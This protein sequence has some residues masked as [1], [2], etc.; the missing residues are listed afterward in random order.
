MDIDLKIKISPFPV[1]V[2]VFVD[3]KELGKRRHRISY[4]L[5]VLD[6]ETLEKLCEDFRSSVFEQAEKKPAPHKDN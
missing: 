3:N 1:P 6:I 5:S 4:P 2:S